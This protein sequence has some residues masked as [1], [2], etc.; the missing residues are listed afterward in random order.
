[1]CIATMK[2]G[3][4][5]GIARCVDMLDTASTHD[6]LDSGET[7]CMI[8]KSNVSRTTR[9]R[10]SALRYG[11]SG[12]K[13]CMTPTNRMSL[14]RLLAQ[15]RDR[16]VAIDYLVRKMGEAIDA[17]PPQRSTSRVLL[18]PT[19]LIDKSIQCYNSDHV[20]ALSGVVRLRSPINLD[21]S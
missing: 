1:M 8:Q 3:Y 6:H 18:I 21:W 12:T 14:R 16:C 15:Y 7:S 13:V 4:A 5:A 10:L 20:I 17:P 9:G 19:T 2:T 11:S